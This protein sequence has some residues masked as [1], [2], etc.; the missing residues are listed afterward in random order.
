M[1]FE[2]EALGHVPHNTLKLESQTDILTHTDIHP[3]A[4]LGH[5]GGCTLEEKVGCP[6]DEAKCSPMEIGPSTKE[7]KHKDGRFEAHSGK[8][9]SHRYF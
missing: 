5:D 2:W 3:C 6:P 7:N 4:E 1:E 9:R 8:I